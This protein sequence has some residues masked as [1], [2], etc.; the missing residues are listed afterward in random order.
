RVPPVR[1]GD[2]VV[3]AVAVAIFDEIVVAGSV[4]DAEAVD[5][6]TKRRERLSASLFPAR[7]DAEVSHDDLLHRSVGARHP[8]GVGRPVAVGD[9][10]REAP[11]ALQMLVDRRFHTTLR[12]T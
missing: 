3:V 8:S 7:L 1:D 2:A 5:D 10:A 4:L 6:V 11:G 12:S 9:A